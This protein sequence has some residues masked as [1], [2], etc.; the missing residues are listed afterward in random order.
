MF[1]FRW[2]TKA[3]QVFDL[4]NPTQKVEIEANDLGEAWKIWFEKH[5]D[6]N[7]MTDL[8]MIEITQTKGK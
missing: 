1:T 3:F 2:R 4:K 7:Q 8:N 5:L 6:Q